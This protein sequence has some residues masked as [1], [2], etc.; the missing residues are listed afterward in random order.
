MYILHY[1]LQKIDN[2]NVKWYVMH[3]YNDNIEGTVEKLKTLLIL[4]AIEND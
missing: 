4:Y 1:W 3:R 2:F